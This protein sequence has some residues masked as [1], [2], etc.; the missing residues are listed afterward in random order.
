MNGI[1]AGNASQEPVPRKTVIAAVRLDS[2]NGA[3]LALQISRAM[4]RLS[5][6]GLVI[7]FDFFPSWNNLCARRRYRHNTPRMA[8][9]EVICLRSILNVGGIIE[10]KP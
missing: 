10:G 4:N 9:P 5:S 3:I 2:T 1:G 8:A 7:L 6:L